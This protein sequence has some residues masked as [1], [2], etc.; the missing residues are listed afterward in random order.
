MHKNIL[1][2]GASGLIGQKL[3]SKLKSSGYQVKTL[4][5]GNNS[6]YQWDPMNHKIDSKALEGIDVV[7][8]LSGANV[9]KHRW[10]KKFKNEIYD[11][12]IYTNRLLFEAAQKTNHIPKLFITSSATGI[13]PNNGM[14]KLTEESEIGTDFLANTCSHWE[15]E[16][17]NFESVG[18]RTVAL[19]TGIVLAKEGGFL[20]RI[21]APIKWCLGAALGSGKQMTSWIHI[22]DLCNMFIYIIEN[23]NIVG[24]VNATSPQAETNMSITKAI[25]KKMNRSIILPNIPGWVLRILFGEFASELLSDKNVVPRKLLESGFKFQ[26]TNCSEALHDLMAAE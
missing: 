25:A 4:G 2:A 15:Q 13:Y 20:P 9:S 1:I 10:T 23:N 11:S 17:F 19:R 24:P 6:D 26:Y 5:R 12:R 21:S 22:D 16:A 7:I 3:A 8:N 14:Q 18:C